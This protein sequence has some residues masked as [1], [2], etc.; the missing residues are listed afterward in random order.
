M[1]HPVVHQ[2]PAQYQLD[3]HQ[4]FLLDIA[5]TEFHYYLLFHRR[6]VA[7]SILT[8]EIICELD[9]TEQTQSE[10]AQGLFVD[11]KKTLC[12][13]TKN[14]I[15]VCNVIN[16]HA[17]VW[18]LLLEWKMYKQAYN[19]C[20]KHKLEALDLV[21]TKYAESLFLQQHYDKSAKMYA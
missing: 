14:N 6:L 2:I 11:Q 18:H 7:C 1:G 4:N 10:E 21:T 16:E 17:D 20:V 15:F 8:S 19:V 13:F 3:S 5:L 12:I 9:F